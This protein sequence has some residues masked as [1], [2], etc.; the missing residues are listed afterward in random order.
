MNTIWRSVFIAHLFSK[1]KWTKVS[2][3][4]D[5]HMS[6]ML[7]EVWLTSQFIFKKDGWITR[8]LEHFQFGLVCMS[9]KK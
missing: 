2:F 1:G 7:N 8:I 4:D 9:L 3:R 5:Y 6:A